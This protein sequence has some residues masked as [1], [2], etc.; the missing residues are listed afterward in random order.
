M[1][2][3]FCPILGKFTQILLS[4]RPTQGN[5]DEIFNQRFECRRVQI[6]QA[7]NE[8]MTQ[9]KCIVMRLEAK[10]YDGSTF[11]NNLSLFTL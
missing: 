5:F 4:N 7:S 3:I 11:Y 8:V 1:L 2:G 10:Y 9:L 6:V